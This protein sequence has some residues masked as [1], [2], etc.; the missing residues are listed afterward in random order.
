MFWCISLSSQNSNL[1]NRFVVE[2]YS[3][4]PSAEAGHGWDTGN[5]TKSGYIALFATLGAD[6]GYNVQ[7][8]IAYIIGTLTDTIR[9]NGSAASQG[10]TNGVRVYVLWAKV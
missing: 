6:Y 10:S 4:T 2:V 5:K 8:V 1:T 3:V 9:V 7:P